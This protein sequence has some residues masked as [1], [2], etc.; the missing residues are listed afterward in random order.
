[1]IR[2]SPYLIRQEIDSAIPKREM[3]HGV[4]TGHIAKRPA[5]LKRNATS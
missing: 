1:M 4:G 2:I 3:D 5:C